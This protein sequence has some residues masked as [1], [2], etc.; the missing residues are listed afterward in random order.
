MI[1][2]VGEGREIERAN[3]ECGRMGKGVCADKM[4]YVLII[5]IIT[6][7]LVVVFMR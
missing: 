1:E 7:F 4:Y 2:S 3:E 5:M 6:L